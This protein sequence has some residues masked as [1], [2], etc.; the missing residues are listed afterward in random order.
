[1]KKPLRMDKGSEMGHTGIYLIN[2]VIRD[3]NKTV[4]LQPK[5]V[6]NSSTVGYLVYDHFGVKKR[7][8]TA[9]RS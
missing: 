3:I 9:F 6:S 2:K 7:S 4:Y 8:K 5:Y 1:M